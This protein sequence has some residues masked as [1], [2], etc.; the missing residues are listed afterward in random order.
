MKRY[1]ISAFA[2]VVMAAV[3]ATSMVSC[4]NFDDSEIWDKLNEHEQRI[5]ELEKVCS[6]LNSNIDALQAVMIALQ[7]NDY[8]TGVTKICEDGVEI[9]YSLAFAKGGT[10]TIYHGKDGQDGDKGEDGQDGSAPKIGIRKASDGEYYWTADDEWL[11]GEDGEKIPAVVADDSNGKYIT[12]MFRV[13]EDGWYISFDNGNSWRF[14]GEID[15]GS[16]DAIFTDIEI[17]DSYIILTTADGTILEIPTSIVHESTQTLVNQLNINASSLQTI[18]KALRKGEHIASVMPLV[19][20]SAIIGYML[21]FSQTG[22]VTIYHNPNGEENEKDFPIVGVRQVADGIY[23]WTVNGAW[24]LGQSGSKIPV[25]SN[26]SAAP[27]LKAGGGLWHISFDN[28]STWQEVKAAGNCGEEIVKVPYSLVHGNRYSS[29]HTTMNTRASILPYSVIVPSG[30]TIRPKDGYVWGWYTNVNPSTP[31]SSSLASGG[32]VS[33]TYTGNGS[34]IGVTVKKTNDAVIDFSVDGDSPEDY[35]DASDPSIWYMEET[36]TT[37]QANQTFSKVDLGNAYYISLILADGTALQ[38]I[39]QQGVEEKESNYWHDKSFVC[40]GDSITAGSGTTKTYWEFLNEFLN[41]LSMKAMGVSGSC[42]SA[43]SDYGTG[44]SPLINRYTSI[45]DSDVIT[46][47]MG[48]N[49]Y[50]HETP[51]GTIDDK[52]DISFYGALNTII[53]G[54]LAAHPNSRLI[55]ITPTHRYGR[56]TSGILGTAFTYDYIPNGRGHNLKDYVDAIK[57]VCER[58]S[59]P[60]IDLFNISGID[61]SISEVRSKYMPDG[62]HPNEAGH[63]KIA[64]IIAASIEDLRWSPGAGTNSGI[65][66]GTSNAIY[67]Y[68]PQTPGLLS[69]DDTYQRIPLFSQSGQDGTIYKGLSF[70]GNGSGTVTIKDLDSRA[71]VAT[72]KWD[73]ADKIKPHDNSVSRRFDTGSNLSIDI[74]WTLNSTYKTAT[75]LLESGSRAVSPKMSLSFYSD[76]SFTISSCTFIVFCYDSN[77]TY[78]GQI[79]TALNGITHA[80]SQWMAAG[81]RITAATIKALAPK[82]DHIALA[83]YKNEIPTYEAKYSGETFHI[84]SNVYNN[85]SSAED[86]HIGEC[87]VYN[88]GGDGKIWSNTLVQLLKIGFIN[89]KNLWPAATEVRPYGNFVVDNDNQFLYAFVMYSSKSLTYWYKF[90]LPEV[91]EGE[92]NETYGCKVKTLTENDIL[93]SWTTPLQNYVQGACVYDGLIWSTEGFTGTSGAN[94]ARMRV[95]DP[96]KKSEIA[97]FNFFSDGDPVEPEFIEFYNGSCYYGSVQQMYLLELM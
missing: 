74:P 54:I 70:R 56:G 75:G 45:P 55:W 20:K 85:Y 46:I 51:L 57:A 49:D 27:V 42:V 96:S 77:G 95:I 52:G 31:T 2:A 48:T 28:G 76:I 73:K 58:H 8:V 62:L 3:A 94:L 79:N 83:A 64:S 35:L 68:I 32:W 47:Y 81:T 33:T 5:E 13:A 10:V 86:K 93:D 15:N 65:G 12:P 34:A 43:T 63:E 97:V 16:D 89:D 59:V 67:S 61:P 92:W 60:V 1:I 4:V 69:P 82:T 41:P 18:V 53:P 14:Y 38:I 91:S 37:I 25:I 39:T 30:V 11:T 44:N 90:A 19:E 24:H 66:S 40:I 84:Y 9:G 6:R 71:T 22:S 23:Y 72:M 29:G 26:D 17:A 36:V 88:V 7:E 78:L 80:T 50:G 87:C 21:N